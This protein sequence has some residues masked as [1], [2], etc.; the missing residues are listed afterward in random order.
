MYQHP[1]ALF[2]NADH[3]QREALRD[4]DARRLAGQGRS[5]ATDDRVGP[6]PFQRRLVALAVALVTV[7]GVVALI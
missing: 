7:L 2:M 4:A 6:Q 3:Y 1:Q 5:Q